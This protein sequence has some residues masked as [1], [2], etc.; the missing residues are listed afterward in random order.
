MK[1]RKMSL[2]SDL[3]DFY[4]MVFAVSE[5]E[6]A[7]VSSSL[8]P[9]TRLLDVGCGT[10]NKTVIFAQKVRSVVGIDPDASMIN[11]AKKNNSGNNLS[12]EVGDMESLA[13]SF[14]PG[15]FTAV[16][17]M[18]NTLVHITE[19]TLIQKVINDIYGLLVDGGV[20]IGQIL[21]YDYI[22]GNKIT[23]L[24]ILETDKVIFERGYDL[25]QKPIKF[26][27]VIHDKEKGAQFH[28]ETPLYPLLRKELEDML[29]IAGFKNSEFFGS[30][31]GEPLKDDSLPLIVRAY[32]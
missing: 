2:Y 28:N 11:K 10:G 1:E 6:L 9:E 18:G 32:K 22:L 25:S 27:T 3:S 15:A 24:P 20:F 21:H 13:T 12:Y 19:P 23:S 8:P 7:F 30:Y 29:S 5:A 16:T 14:G 26:M 17:C 4:D 31:A